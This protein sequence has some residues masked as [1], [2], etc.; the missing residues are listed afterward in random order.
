MELTNK[1]AD[2]LHK[3][4]LDTKPKPGNP[5]T[6]ALVDSTKRGRLERIT[7]GPLGMYAFAHSW[8]TWVCF[9]KG[10]SAQLVGFQGPKTS[11]GMDFG[12]QTLTIWVLGP[13]GFW[14]RRNCPEGSMC[15][16]RIYLGA[17]STHTGAVHA[18]STAFTIRVEGP[19]TET[20]GFINGLCTK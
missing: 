1:N 8:Q 10:P 4:H 16:S 3:T 15:H 20:A 19:C 9:P 18:K 11:Q 7:G 17:R 2:T 13:S 12:T 14:R 5:E 6:R